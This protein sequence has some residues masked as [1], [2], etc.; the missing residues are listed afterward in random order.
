M[1]PVSIH[2][3]YN[4]R[5]YSNFI[6]E[7]LNFVS[8]KNKSL[9]KR[10]KLLEGKQLSVESK[11]FM[12]L[13]EI[14]KKTHIIGKNH[15]EIMTF[16]FY[17]DSTRRVM[18]KNMHIPKGSLE[19][20]KI[21]GNI[22]KHYLKDFRRMKKLNCEFEIDN[23]WERKTGIS[24]KNVYAQYENMKHFTK[25]SDSDDEHNEDDY[26]EDDNNKE[27]KIQK[28]RVTSKGNITK[29]P[30]K[31]GRKPKPKPLQLPLTQPSGC[32][33]ENPFTTSPYTESLDYDKIMEIIY[34]PN[35]ID[36]VNWDNVDWNTFADSSEFCI[37]G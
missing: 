33:T 25:F 9:K 19:Y 10:R 8:D 26:Y 34:S 35:G 17:W 24:K 12:L 20:D 13:E 29:I 4:Y 30:A 21:K 1:P 3:F 16:K 15:S 11:I 2:P 6:Q 32:N 18:C 7:N 23:K 5:K 28:S 31:R 14:E 36:C 22:L 37:F 27:Y